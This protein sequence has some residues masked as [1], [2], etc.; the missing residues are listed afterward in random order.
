MYPNDEPRPPPSYKLEDEDY[1]YYI[2]GVAY[3]MFLLSFLLGHTIVALLLCEF[4][5]LASLDSGLT[6][7]R[8]RRLQTPRRQAKEE[9]RGACPTAAPTTTTPQSTYD[10][11][12]GPLRRT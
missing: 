2:S 11:S 1:N 3:F 7:L 6:Q 9:A 12:H 5:N 4:I 8:Q 10:K